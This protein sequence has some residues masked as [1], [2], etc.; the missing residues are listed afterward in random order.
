M[1][2]YEEI[3]QRQRDYYN[4][5]ETKSIDFRLRQ[6]KKLQALLNNNE[7]LF[8]EA[9]Y[10]DFKKSEFDTYGTEFS[11]IYDGLRN[12]IKNVGHWAKRNLSLPIFSIYLV[13][14]LSFLN[15]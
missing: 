6:L 12:A 1:I 4:T 3:V 11:Q 14:V 13:R 7:S 15:H 10:A 2:H 9:I 8:Y 5:N